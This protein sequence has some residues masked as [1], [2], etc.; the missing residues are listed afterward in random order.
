[1]IVISVRFGNGLAGHVPH[2]AGGLARQAG[3][4]AGAGQLPGQVDGVCLQWCSHDLLAQEQRKIL[5]PRAS[6]F[7]RCLPGAMPPSLS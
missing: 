4:H 7:R 1:V 6:L 2:L 5:T 3:G